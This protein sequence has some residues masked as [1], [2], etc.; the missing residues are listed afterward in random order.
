MAMI[1]NKKE[2]T[3][4]ELSR[5]ITA[6]L[7]EK[8]QKSAEI[9]NASPDF[10]EDSEYVKDFQ[11]TGRFAWVWAVLIVAALIISILVIVG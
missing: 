10:T 7:R 5:R 4:D 9:G 3:N 1:L 2:D 8:A 11:K 6:D